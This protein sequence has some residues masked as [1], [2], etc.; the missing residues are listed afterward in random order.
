MLFYESEERPGTLNDDFTPKEWSKP[1]NGI[2]QAAYYHY[3]DYYRAVTSSLSYDE[4]IQL[5]YIVDKRMIARLKNYTPNGL[6][7]RFIKFA[8]IKVL[9]AKIKFGIGLDNKAKTFNEQIYNT[10]N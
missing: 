5:K 2:D 9:Q 4:I 8:V 7:V 3:C 10:V 6:M 1:L